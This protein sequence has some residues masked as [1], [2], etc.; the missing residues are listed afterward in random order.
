MAKRKGMSVNGLA[1]IGQILQRNPEAAKPEAPKKVRDTID[2]IVEKTLSSVP[3]G[4]TACNLRTY[5]TAAV[6]AGYNL[7]H[8]D[9]FDQNGAVENLLRQQY[10]ARTMLTL[11]TA[12][13][14]IMEQVGMESMM[15]D[16]DQV[17]TVF[18]RV[19]LVTESLD[20]NSVQYTLTHQADEAAPDHSFMLKG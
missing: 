5:V 18:N 6:R 20:D 14:A 17:A 16:L 12:V 13:A 4:S 8:A 1:N 10:E 3:L 15:L 7:G 11:P 19:R 9:A 2:S